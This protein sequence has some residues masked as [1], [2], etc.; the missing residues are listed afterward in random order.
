V[1]LAQTKVSL[2]TEGHKA[3]A[4]H[5]AGFKSGIET[6]SVR[7]LLFHLPPSPS[8]PLRLCSVGTSTKEAGGIRK[9]KWGNMCAAWPSLTPPPSPLTQAVQRWNKHKVDAWATHERDAA[10]ARAMHESNT[11]RMRA[12]WE[13]RETE[14]GLW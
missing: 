5:T 11:A 7:D 2:V 9:N 8:P 1:L 13:A 3:C 6:C 12:E 4:L 14:V 10:A